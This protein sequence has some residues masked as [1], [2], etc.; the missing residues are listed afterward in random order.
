VIL[1]FGAVLIA[2]T[3]WGRPTALSSLAVIASG[4]VL[5]GSAPPAAAHDPGQGQPLASTRL[6]GIS[7]GRGRLAVTVRI[8]DC[9]QITPVEVVARRAGRSLTGKLRPVGDCRYTGSVQVA[10]QG[11]WFVYAEFRR[12]GQDAQ[13][14]LPMQADQLGRYSETRE[15][16][17]PARAT[18][19]TR[20]VEL[21]AAVTIYALGLSLLSSAIWL[22]PRKRRASM[23]R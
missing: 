2:T 22:V 3:R 13:V 21:V 20:P 14:W 17:A 1:A 6:T 5:L 9:A 18:A 23:A 16:Y 7:D 4:A 12:G 8:P 19:S 15:L 10:P 11:R